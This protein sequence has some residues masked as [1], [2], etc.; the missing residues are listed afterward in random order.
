MRRSAFPGAAR[1][2]SAHSSASIHNL[3]T[4]IFKMLLKFSIERSILYR[5]GCNAINGLSTIE[6]YRR[7]FFQKL[8]GGNK[9]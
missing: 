3:V 4:I 6:P 8:K 2:Y 5:Q 1:L 7:K 9:T